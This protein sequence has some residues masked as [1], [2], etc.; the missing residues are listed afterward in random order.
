[1]KPR[2]PALL[3]ILLISACGPA[4]P[5]AK[6]IQKDATAESWYAETVNRL[7]ALDLEANHL[8]QNGKADA[9]AALIEK[10][11]PLSKKLLAVRNPTLGALE[12]AS[13]LDQIYGRMLFS[14][15]NYGW[16]RL[17]FQKNAARWK[18]WRPQTSETARRLDEARKAIV[19]CDSRIVQ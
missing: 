10:G 17:M 5:P 15:R 11:E 12:A 3:A 16:A 18:N 13:D 2:E 4:A 19:E 6:E 14:N 7:A 8:F 9:A 1:M